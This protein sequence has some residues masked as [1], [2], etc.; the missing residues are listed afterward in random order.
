M[1][2]LPEVTLTTSS[3]KSQELPP[4]LVELPGE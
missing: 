4:D 3:A 1:D 2:N